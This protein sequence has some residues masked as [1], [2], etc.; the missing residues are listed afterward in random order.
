MMKDIIRLILINYILMMYASSIDPFRLPSTSSNP[1]E[2]PKLILD[3]GC[4]P[5]G[6]WSHG[7][8]KRYGAQTQTHLR[9]I[10]LDLCP[11]QSVL[12]SLHSHHQSEFIQHDFLNHP[13]PFPDDT[14]DYIHSSF[15]ATGIPEDKWSKLLEEILRVLKPG[16][17]FELIETNLNPNLKTHE[18]LDKHFISPFPLSIIPAQLSMLDDGNSVERRRIEFEEKMKQEEAERS[19]SSELEPIQTEDHQKKMKKSKRSLNLNSQLNLTWNLLNHTHHLSLNVSQARADEKPSLNGSN[20]MGKARSESDRRSGMI[21]HLLIERFGW[22]PLMDLHSFQ[23]LKVQYQDSLKGLSLME[24]KLN[25]L[26]TNL[27]MRK[28]RKEEMKMRGDESNEG[29]ES[30]KEWMEKMMLKRSEMKKSSQLIRNEF[31]NVQNRLGIEIGLSASLNGVDSSGGGGG[32]GN[33]NEEEMDEK[34]L[35]S[36]N[37]IRIESFLVSKN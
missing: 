28:Q 36:K 22:K 32:G 8:F 12:P 25:E 23:S 11:V 3:L 5:Y 31:L 30:V 1:L 33:S 17:K 29:M 2:L 24:S 21:S 16:Q 13:L 14:F 27:K 10:G 37:S 34:S 18:I 35:N 4:G 7:V 20:L 19:H 9:I 26:K 15:I 6:T